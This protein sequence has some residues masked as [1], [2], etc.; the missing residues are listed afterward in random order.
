M[1]APH[2]PAKNHRKEI[3]A[4]EVELE[5]DPAIKAVNSGTT[6]IKKTMNLNKSTNGKFTLGLNLVETEVVSLKTRRQ[7][8][9]VGRLMEPARAEN[10]ANFQL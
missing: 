6:T 8:P 2:T 9:S 1:F 3:M 7:C 10:S 4:F 5:K